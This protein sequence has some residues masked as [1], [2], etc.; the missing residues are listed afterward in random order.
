MK[1]N[2]LN[3]TNM[4]T[5]KLLAIPFFCL[6]LFTSCGDDDNPAP[7]NEEEVITTMTVT[8]TPVGGGATVTLKTQDLDGDGPDAPDVDVTGTFVNGT[9]YNGTVEFLDE[10][11]LNDVEDITAEVEEEGDEHQ[12]FF[13]TALGTTNYSD[14]DINGNPI[15]LSFTFTPSMTAT[16]GF[17]V[18][19]RHEP[20]KDATGVS[21]GD[22]TN[23]GGETD[24]T[25]TFTVTVQ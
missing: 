17:T 7:V 21:T 20:A 2:F 18:T 22:I 4:K 3:L 14:M 5:I 1:T 15:G 23:A 16:G 24:I 8:L 6:A 19:L 25:E 11:D 10:T 13:S 12:I 9:V